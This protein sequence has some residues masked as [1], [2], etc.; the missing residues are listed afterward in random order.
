MWLDNLILFAQ[1]IDLLLCIVWHGAVMIAWLPILALQN[2]VRRDKPCQK[3]NMVTF[4]EGHVMHTRRAPVVNKFTYPVRVAV[5]SLDSPPSWFMNQSSDHLTASEARAFAGA[6]RGKVELLTNPRTMGYTQ[7]PISVYYCYK[8]G[9]KEVE[10]C[11]AEV[12]NTPWNER[13]RFCF[14]SSNGYAR[15]G[16]SLHVSP[17][18]DMRGTW[19]LNAPQPS[20]Q[21]RLVVKVEHPRHGKDFF[22]A[23][24]T[25]RKSESPGLR[26]EEGGL[27]MLSRYGFQPH[28]TAILIYWQALVLISKGLPL[29]PLPTRSTKEAAAE[30]ASHPTCQ[31]DHGPSF[32]VWTPPPRW[33][34]NYQSSPDSVQQKCPF[35]SR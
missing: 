17:F 28:R 34:W 20:D 8:E 12:T 3:Y 10:K 14:D 1:A 32:F 30:N 25:A 4:F 6:T 9:D 13:V 21:L 16:K 24:L 29:H 27:G 2:I 31:T 26:S 33:P 15:V 19:L 23:E 18:M 11:I 7:N 22:H 5:I 35:S